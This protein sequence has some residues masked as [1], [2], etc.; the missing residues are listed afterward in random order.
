MSQN[1]PQT[2]IG[3]MLTDQSLS[4]YLKNRG[5]KM[6]VATIKKNYAD[7]SKCPPSG[8]IGATRYYKK[9]QVEMW[10]D[11]KFQQEGAHHA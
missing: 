2:V 9:E 7:L 11:E 10:I 1:L 4:D 3:D 6:S 8:K 5:I